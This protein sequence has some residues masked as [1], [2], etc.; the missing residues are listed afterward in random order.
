MQSPTAPL[1]LTLS[2]LERTTSMSPRFQSPLSRNGAKLSPMLLLI[3][4]K[5][6]YM[7]SPMTP[8]HLTLSDLE[9]SRSLRF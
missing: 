6:A 1:D 5:K 8:R 9:R 2:E 3:I 7:A 4:N